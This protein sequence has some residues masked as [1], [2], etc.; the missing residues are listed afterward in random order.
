GDLVATLL[1]EIKIE[2]QLLSG[3]FKREA[4]AR[5]IPG[6]CI[7]KWPFRAQLRRFQ[8][9]FKAHGGEVA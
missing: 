4:F 8:Q 2:S 5:N 6:V 1:N 3:N 7:Y 9:R